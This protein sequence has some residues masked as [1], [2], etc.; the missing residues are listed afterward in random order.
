M[1][2]S[3]IVTP[4]CHAFGLRTPSVPALMMPAVIDTVVDKDRMK[5]C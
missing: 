5:Y 4:N 3:L 1:G 2:S